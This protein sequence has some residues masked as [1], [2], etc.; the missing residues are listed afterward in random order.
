MGL[1]FG[2]CATLKCY[3]TKIQQRDE[4]KDTRLQQLNHI[5]FKRHY[6][7]KKLLL[8]FLLATRLACSV[9]LSRCERNHNR[10]ETNSEC[11]W[12][13][14][15]CHLRGKS[16]FIGCCSISNE[17]AVNWIGIKDSTN[18]TNSNRMFVAGQPS[19]QITNFVLA[20][21]AFEPKQFHEYWNPCKY[22]LF[23]LFLCCVWFGW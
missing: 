7:K 1:S 19:N 20:I 3:E 6:E 11:L 15:L 21:H 2:L 12:V 17:W 18:Y 5:H 23:V 16:I 10:I 22:I 13:S 9:S 14:G 8:H 4:K